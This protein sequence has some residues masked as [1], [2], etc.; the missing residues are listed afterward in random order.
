MANIVTR[1]KSILF[2]FFTDF[3]RKDGKCQ[4]TADLKALVYAY[5]CQT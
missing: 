2:Q 3:D 4:S 5:G 1:Y